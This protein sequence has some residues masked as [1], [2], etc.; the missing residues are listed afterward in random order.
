MGN[1]RDQL[2]QAKLLS[3]KAAK[4]LAH[5]ERIHRSQAGSEGLEQE[6]QDRRTELR[7]MQETQRAET[8]ESQAELDARRRQREARAACEEILRSEA[9][10]PQRGGQR[11]FYFELA[12]GRIPQLSLTD[13]EHA[14]MLAGQ[15]G[16]VCTGSPGALVFGLLPVDLAQR[17][18]EQL[19]E[20]LAWTP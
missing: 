4:R 12:D 3:K 14:A 9:R 10:P 15:F 18:G 17:V 16:V 20:A 11:R 7:E 19:P 2:K 13:V 6:Q 1:L 8:R 5:E